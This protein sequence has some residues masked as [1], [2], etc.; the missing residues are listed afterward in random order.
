MMQSIVTV[1]NQTLT[2]PA[3]PVVTFNRKLEKMISRMKRTIR[4]AK[5]P[6]GV[7]LAGPQAGLPFQIFLTRPTVKDDI[8]VFINPKI[9]SRS[10]ELTDGVPQRENKLEGC[11][12]IPAV[13]GKVKRA[14]TLVLSYRDE[15]G[16]LHEET[17]EGFMATII[18]H[19]MDHLAGILFTQRVMEQKGKLFQSGRDENGKEVLEEIKLK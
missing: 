15:T 13:W 16:K 18:Q 2:T 11:L 9:I 19:E 4:A 1:P 3:K 8:R 14:T 10:E 17:F 7:G 6:I 5:H 12:S